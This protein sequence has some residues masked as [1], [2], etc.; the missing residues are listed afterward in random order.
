MTEQAQQLDTPN[1]SARAKRTKWWLVGTAVLV[2]AILGG[3]WLTHPGAVP[4]GPGEAG[5]PVELGQTYVSTHLV[6]PSRPIKVL[7]LKPYALAGAHGRVRFFA[8]LR[9]PGP[10]WMLQP[11]P[12][13]EACARVGSVRAASIRIGLVT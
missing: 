11:S 6:L 9:H 1:P 13:S 3:W 2:L 10:G 5:G 12:K 8:C 7:S 4:G